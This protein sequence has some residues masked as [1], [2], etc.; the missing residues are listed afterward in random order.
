MDGITKLIIENEELKQAHK[1]LIIKLK[2]WEQL[3]SMS[4]RNTKEL[5]R[6]EIKKVIKENE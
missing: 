1:D 3:L 5:V 6:K 4:G 2:V